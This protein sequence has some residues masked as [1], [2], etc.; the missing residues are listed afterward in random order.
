MAGTRMISLK[1]ALAKLHKCPAINHLHGKAD[2][3]LG[4]PGRTGASL[5]K[6]DVLLGG[7]QN[8]RGSAECKC[9]MAV[10]QGLIRG[11]TLPPA[12]SFRAFG[13]AKSAIHTYD[14]ESQVVDGRNCHASGCPVE[15]YTINLGHTP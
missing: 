15:S 2:Q 8:A 9:S 7:M 11:L 10:T 6:T 3:V 1:Q 4:E 13:P 14:R 5:V 12:I